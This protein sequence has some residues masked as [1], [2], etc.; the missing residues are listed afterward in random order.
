MLLIFNVLKAF[1]LDIPARFAELKAR[2]EHRVEDATDQTLHVARD[3]AVTVALVCCAA[4][5]ALAAIAI[6]LVALARWVADLYGPFAGLAAVGGILLLVTVILVVVAM[7]R[8]R[9]ARRIKSPAKVLESAAKRSAAYADAARRLP[10]AQAELASTGAPATAQASRAGSGP[11]LGD[12]SKLIGFL[13]PLLLRSS[14]SEGGVMSLLSTAWRAGAPKTAGETLEGAAK[15]V[16]EG[17]RMNLFAVIGA[18][19]L[20]GWLVSGRTFSWPLRGLSTRS[21]T[22]ERKKSEAA[23]LGAES[24]S[25]AGSEVK[26]WRRSSAEALARGK[27]AASA[28]GAEAAGASASAVQS[29]RS[30]IKNI[31]ELVARLAAQ[32]G[33]DA[34]GVAAAAAERV[35]DVAGDLARGGAN[36]AAAATDRAKSFAGELEGMARRNPMGV[37]A[38][39]V[40]IGVL[41][42]VFG[43][44]R[45]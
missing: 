15:M 39:A 35:G 36:A 33:R 43:R 19:V 16:R 25:V 42:G 6:G 20:F 5:T 21:R 1:G 18:A 45:R 40:V 27:E 8:P 12:L 17:D 4:V 3:I 11:S 23:G 32:S 26:D 22:M 34:A 14:A 38:G 37:I 41:I 31:Q 24:E 7:T 10:A 2:I 29:L 9:S 13:L 28:A 44:G 30:E